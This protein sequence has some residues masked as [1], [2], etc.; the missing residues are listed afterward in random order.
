MIARCALAHMYRMQMEAI[1]QV[2]VMRLKATQRALYVPNAQLEELD[3]DVN[4]VKM[5]I[6]VTLRVFMGKSKHARN[7]NVMA[8]L[9]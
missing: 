6:L 4:C 2:L 7:A 5:D 8:T 3:P 9:T 1:D